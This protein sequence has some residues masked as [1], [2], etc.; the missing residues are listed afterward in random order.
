MRFSRAAVV[1]AM[2]IVVSAFASQAQAQGQT[3]PPLEAYGK[4]VRLIEL[5][6][7]DHWLSREET[8]LDMLK[9]AVSFVEKHNPPD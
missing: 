3:A 2:F 6:G 1:A 9:A 8:R 5:D 7:E 4:P